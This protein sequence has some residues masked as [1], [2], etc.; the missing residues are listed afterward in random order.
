MSIHSLRARLARAGLHRPVGWLRNFGLGPN[1]VLIASHG[2]SGDTMLR[3]VLGEILSGIPTSFDNIQQIVPEIG[4]HSKAYL[5]L[6]GNGRLI[7]S[8]EPCN[9]KYPRAIYLIRD[10]RDALL[11]FFAR[12]TAVACI[13]PNYSDLDAYIP[14]FLQ[15]KVTH[16]GSWQAHVDGWIN[17]PLAQRGDLLLV[18]FEDLRR[19]TAREIARCL[20]FIG[21]RADPSVIEA[22]IR[23]NSLENMRTKENQSIKFPKV[24]GEQGR[25]IGRGVIEGWRGTLTPQHLKL[26]DEY[27]GNILSRFGYPTGTSPNPPNAPSLTPPANPPIPASSHS[28]AVQPYQ[29]PKYR[30]PVP[31]D[32]LPRRILRVR[33]GGQ[34]ANFFSWYRY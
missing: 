32:A 27:A 10:V 8:H 2:R 18:R 4:V 24:P 31:K 9:R 6:P 3:F 22:A 20:D 16:F 33:L 17:S 29:L 34:I 1:D 11:S 25:Q 12:E 5:I 15:G 19:D 7:K 28:S 14:A 30:R 21:A 23:N 26:I 13:N